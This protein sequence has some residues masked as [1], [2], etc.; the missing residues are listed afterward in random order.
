[1][2][3]PNSS[4][5]QGNEQTPQRWARIVDILDDGTL[6]TEDAERLWPIGIEFPNGGDQ[7]AEA[8]HLL[9]ELTNDKIV[10]FSV[11]AVNRKGILQVTLWS[12]QKNVN[13]LLLT[14]GYKESAQD[15]NVT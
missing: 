1:M 9:S 11:H 14:K 8:L 4:E 6:Y 2:N 3:T 12:D 5:I 13:E 15:P 7:K 10:F